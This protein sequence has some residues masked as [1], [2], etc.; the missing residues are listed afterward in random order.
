MYGILVKETYCNWLVKA[1]TKK[2][3]SKIDSFLN[4]GFR[5]IGKKND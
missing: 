4:M 2:F 5:S 3:S 1:R